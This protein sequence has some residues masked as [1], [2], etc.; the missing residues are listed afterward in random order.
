MIIEKMKFTN[1]ID[2]TTHFSNKEHCIDYLTELRWPNGVKC[3]FC[4]HQKIYELKGANKR[5]K[6]ARC[7][8]QFSV[9]KGTIFENSPIPL[10]KWFMAVFIL[11]THKKG[12]SSLQLASDLGITQKSAWFMAQRIRYALKVKNFDKQISGVIQADE[13]F[14]GG[15]NKNRKGNKKVANSQGRSVKDKTPVFGMIQ[16]GGMLIT[17]VVPNTRSETLKPIIENMVADGSIIVTDEWLG[18]KNL[19][20]KYYHVTLNHQEDE[21]A[22]GAFHNNSIEG[23]WGLFKR[24]IFGIYHQVSRKH[25]HRYCDEFAYRYNARKVC[26]EVR[27]ENAFSLVDCRLTYQELI[28]K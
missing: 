7:Y 20:S 9:T 19:S 2:V 25:L 27:F 1:L 28:R 26:N 13:T 24:G 15:K 5:Y 23:F 22:R 8:K 6:C 21:Y 17:R 16:T 18:Y 11:T 4:D 14:I 3:V 10:Q 12:V